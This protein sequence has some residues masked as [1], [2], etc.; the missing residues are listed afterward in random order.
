MSLLTLYGAL[1]G[2]GGGGGVRQSASESIWSRE[3]KAVSILER[4]QMT[5]SR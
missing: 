3:V 5:Q 1:R 2:G 4:R